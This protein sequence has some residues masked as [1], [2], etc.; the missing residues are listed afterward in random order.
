MTPGIIIQCPILHSHAV[1][2]YR[3]VSTLHDKEWQRKAAGMNK[4]REKALTLILSS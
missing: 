4:E 1:A 2:M 3:E